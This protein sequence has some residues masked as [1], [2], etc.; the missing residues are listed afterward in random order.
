MDEII[1]RLGY[2]EEAIEKLESLKQRVKSVHPDWYGE[3]EG[4]VKEDKKKKWTRNGRTIWS[5]KGDKEEET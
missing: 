4:K 2:M 1:E 5:V 3:K